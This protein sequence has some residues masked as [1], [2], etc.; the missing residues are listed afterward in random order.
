MAIE[1]RQVATLAAKELRDRLRNR[2]VLAVATV[3]AVFSLV[4]C[5]FGGAEQGTLGPRSLEFVI[6]S[7]VSLV[8]YLIPMIALL[9][10]FDAVVGERERGS[11][12]LLLALPVT[13]FEVLLG[14]YLGLAVALTLSTLAGFALMVVLLW[15]QFGW[16]G[17]YHAFGFVVSSILL[18]LVFLSLSLLISVASR[19][20]TRAS[21]AAIG[22]W[23]G[24]VLV[25]DLLMLGLLVASGGSFGGEAL[26]YVLLLNPTDIFRILN[27][28]SLEQ[29]RGLQGLVS[30]VPPALGNPW[31]MGGAM[32]GW[33]AAPLALAAWRF[34]L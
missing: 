23:F 12:D 5:Y 24:F 25:F 22:L 34:R 16:V 28:F 9:L 17:L 30:I 32:L 2:W 1:C 6:T 26:A 10:G 3:F 11:L 33:I 14:K 18:G 8:I 27:V 13:R 19:D 29:L 31:A 7:L 21:G 15:Q 4:I 20:R